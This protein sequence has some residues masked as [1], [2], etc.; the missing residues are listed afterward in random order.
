MNK[1][2]LMDFSKRIQDKFFIEG[3]HT[4]TSEF[5]PILKVLRAFLKGFSTLHFVG[6]CVTV[7]GSALVDEENEYYIK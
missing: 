3:T 6:P 4:R 5:W 7:F 1:N 2:K